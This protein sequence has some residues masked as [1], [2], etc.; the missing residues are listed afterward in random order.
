M[1]NKFSL[2]KLMF[3]T[4]SIASL[5]IGITQIHNPEMIGFCLFLATMG[6]LSV[7]V[8]HIEEKK[9]LEYNENN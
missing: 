6:I 9:E 1:L 4:I 3:S 2:C 7:Y 5:A 8:L